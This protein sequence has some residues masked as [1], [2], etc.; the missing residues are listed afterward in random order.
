MDQAVSG[1]DGDRLPGG[2]DHLM[3]FDDQGSVP[4]AFG[5]KRHGGEHA[6]PFGRD[7][8]SANFENNGS[9]SR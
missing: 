2:V 7:I 1:R 4:L 3:L 5:G 9:F 8:V 6:R